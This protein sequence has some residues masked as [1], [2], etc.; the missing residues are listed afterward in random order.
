MNEQFRLVISQLRTERL[1]SSSSCSSSAPA[2]GV[3]LRSR[4]TN[5]LIDA[6]AVEPACTNSAPVLFTTSRYASV[7]AAKILVVSGSFHLFRR[8]VKCSGGLELRVVEQHPPDAAERA[9]RQQS[10]PT[11]PCAGQ[12]ARSMVVRDRCRMM[13]AIFGSP[14]LRSPQRSGRVPVRARFTSD[15][16]SPRQL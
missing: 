12:P 15:Y 4:K 13:R 10:K 14:L 1:R 2:A 11:K 8:G 3:A 6:S 7:I 5:I 16:L 9:G